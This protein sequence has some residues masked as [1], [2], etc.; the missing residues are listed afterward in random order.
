MIADYRAAVGRMW[1]LITLPFLLLAV[2]LALIACGSNK[3]NT[4]ATS[5]PAASAAASTRGAAASPSTGASAAS[6]TRA[7]ANIRRGGTLNLATPF[8]EIWQALMTR[9]GK[10]IGTK[11]MIELLKLSRQFGREHV[12]RAIDA[13]RETGCTDIAAVQHLVHA[14]SLHRPV[15]EAMEIGSLELYKRPLPVM[16]DDDQLL[17]EGE[18]R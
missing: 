16:A 8:D 4:A 9:Y 15:C 14:H 11:H 10:Q 1:R 18:I 5:A 2:S 3:N 12:R 13:A 17:T 7:A 6:P